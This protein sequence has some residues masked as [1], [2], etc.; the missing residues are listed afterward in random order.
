M[1]NIQMIPPGNGSQNPCRFSGRSY[2]AALGSVISVPDFDAN[3]LES[4]GWI[5]CAGHGAGTTAQ[6]PTTGLFRGMTYFDSTVG[7]NMIWDG[8]AWRNHATGA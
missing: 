2:T 3:V 8:N 4:N 1:A 5:R 7:A 6:R